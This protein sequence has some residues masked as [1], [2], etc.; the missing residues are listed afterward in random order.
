MTLSYR[1]S[2]IFKFKLEK[3]KIDKERDMQV[4]INGEIRNITHG[5][6]VEEL[7]HGLG[8]KPGTAVVE[9]N[10]NIVKVN[11]YASETIPADSVIEII[12]FVGGG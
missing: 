7:L 3:P 9:L 5:K 6:T 12:R 10:Q 1:L 2:I 4:Q 8:I 11:R